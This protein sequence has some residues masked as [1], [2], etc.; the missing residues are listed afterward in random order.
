MK[1]WDGNSFGNWRE[2]QN[3]TTRNT[4]TEVTEASLDV[5]KPDARENQ[6]EL[7]KEAVPKL[8]SKAQSFGH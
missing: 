5:Q 1:E 2:S 8:S 3:R 6:V 4:A 7:K